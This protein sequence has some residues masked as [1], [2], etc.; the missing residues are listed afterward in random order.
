MKIPANNPCFIVIGADLYFINGRRCWCCW[1]IIF[2]QLTT[3]R[4]ANTATNR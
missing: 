1:Y 4:N 2:L 3:I